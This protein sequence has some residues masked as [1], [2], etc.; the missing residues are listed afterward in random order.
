VGGL[1]QY[2]VFDSVYRTLLWM[3]AYVQVTKMIP[4]DVEATTNGILKTLQ[5]GSTQVYGRLLAV[6]LT[7]LCVE[8]G[9]RYYIAIILV[10]ILAF[11]LALV[12]LALLGLL[13]TR[14]EVQDIQYT[15]L[16]QML[17]QIKEERIVFGLEE[18]RVM[19]ERLRGQ[20]G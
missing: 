2:A 10:L 3:P 7:Q 1:I 15:I 14:E 20:E 9:L 13:A 16:S 8:L 19:V 4:S 11:I 5:A 6:C 12:Q 18:V 17:V